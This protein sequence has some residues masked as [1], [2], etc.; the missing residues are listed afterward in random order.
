MSTIHG[1][2]TGDNKN[3][4]FMLIGDIAAVLGMSLDTLYQQLNHN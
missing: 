1:I 3:P 4:G 2:E